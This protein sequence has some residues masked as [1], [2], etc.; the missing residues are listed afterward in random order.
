MTRTHKKVRYPPSSKENKYTPA[1]AASGL[2]QAFASATRCPR[3]IPEDFMDPSPAPLYL[4]FLNRSEVGWRNA[5]FCGCLV[6]RSDPK[7]RRLRKRPSEEHD[8][9]R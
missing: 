7:E 4:Q 2:E 3:R 6:R 8:P 9:E 1:T 5:V